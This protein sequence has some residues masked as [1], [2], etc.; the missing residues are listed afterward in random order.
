MIIMRPNRLRPVS[1]ARS[2]VLH[3][4]APQEDRVHISSQAGRSHLHLQGAVIVIRYEGP[5]GGPGMPEMLTPTSAIMGAG[6]GQVMVT[7]LALGLGM[8]F[9]PPAP[10]WTLDLH[11]SHCGDGLSP[12]AASDHGLP[13]GCSFWFRKPCRCSKRNARPSTR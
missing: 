2:I 13:G 11:P 9:G 10:N 8:G 7:A 4:V 5:K 12:G 1:S 6:L 3:V